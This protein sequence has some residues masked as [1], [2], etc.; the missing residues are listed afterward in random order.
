MNQADL[1]EA[2]AA[3][4]LARQDGER[5]DANQQRQ[6]DDWIAAALA[7]RIAYLRLS[8]LWQRAERLGSLRVPPPPI[9]A[10]TD[11]AAAAPPPEVADAGPEPAMP[12]P[13]NDRR[14]GG[15]AANG[16]LWQALAAMLIVAV[17]TALFSRIAWRGESDSLATALGSRR[18]VTLVDGSRLLLNTD[19][20]MEVDLG[21]RRR[22]VRLDR[23]EAYF[24]IAHDAARPFVIDAGN[25]RITV[26]G[27]KFAVRRGAEQVSVLVTE[28]RVKVEPI[29]VP[30]GSAVTTINRNDVLVAT[31]NGLLV[32]RKTDAQVADELSWRQGTL[33]FDQ[34]TLAQA[35]AEF[36][37]YNA[38][39]LVIADRE[40][41][42]MVLG[43]RF[44]SNNVA[45]FA[46]LLHTGLGLKVEQ[47]PGEIR[48]SR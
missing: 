44:D 22:L 47:R 39:K 45:S 17:T 41:G 27:T 46:Q 42:E 8:A 40:T 48:V 20:R 10:R 23:G 12:A 30:A 29:N 4:W 14:R 13:A 25:S 35:A 32:S 26:L 33:V 1:I 21:Q 15:P 7:H 34:V 16:A 6:L 19:T 31:R 28:G 11:D 3:D 18:A 2:Q 43:G 38:T 36:N 37:R 24:E 5:W 9:G